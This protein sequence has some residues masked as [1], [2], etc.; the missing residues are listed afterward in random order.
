MRKYKL[1]DFA[2]NES[3]LKRLQFNSVHPIDAEE[4]TNNE[5]VII[6]IA[7]LGGSHWFC[8]Y[9]KDKN[10]YYFDNFLVKQLPRAITF[11]NYKI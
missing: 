4:T 9:K 7:N 10:S 1:T 11:H 8:Y 3:G 2:M 5:S 6:D